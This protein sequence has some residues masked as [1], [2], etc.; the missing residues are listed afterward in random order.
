MRRSSLKKR[1]T[2]QEKKNGCYKRRGE[3]ERNQEGFPPPQA[4]SKMASSRERRESF[5]K[6]VHLKF[7]EPIL[8][9]KK[10]LAP[11]LYL[12]VL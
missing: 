3:E 6:S 9:N 5:L 12:L 11:N 1:E 8:K 10:Y 7:K 2:Q 4:Y